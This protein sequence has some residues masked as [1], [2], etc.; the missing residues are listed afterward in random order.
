MARIDSLLHPKQMQTWRTWKPPCTCQRKLRASHA[1]A[2]PVAHMIKHCRNQRQSTANGEF[3]QLFDR[4]M[5]GVVTPS[6]ARRVSHIGTAVLNL[7]TVMPRRIG[8]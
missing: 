3:H 6:I 7:S 4:L 2:I 1:D 8:I 5:V